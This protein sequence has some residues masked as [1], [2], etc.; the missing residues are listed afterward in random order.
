MSEARATPATSLQFSPDCPTDSLI[1][2]L[3][4]S[5]TAVVCDTFSFIFRL[6]VLGTL[7]H[8]GVQVLHL[9]TMPKLCDTGV[10]RGVWMTWRHTR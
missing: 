4:S 5:D 6:L 3:G 1:T 9:L 8:I 10:I 2:R 7:T